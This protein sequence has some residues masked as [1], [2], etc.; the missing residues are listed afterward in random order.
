MGRWCNGN[1][2][3]SKFC[4]IIFIYS[5]MEQFGSSRGSFDAKWSKNKYYR[6]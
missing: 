6:T 5:G 1:I 4:K 2:C 3:A